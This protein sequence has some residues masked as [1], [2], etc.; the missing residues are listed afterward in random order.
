[1]D[2]IN[3]INL[4]IDKH[5]ISRSCAP[6]EIISNYLCDIFAALFRLHTLDCIKYKID[7]K[8]KNELNKTIWSSVTNLTVN[9]PQTIHESLLTIGCYKFECVL[10]DIKVQCI[11]C[12][13]VIM[14]YV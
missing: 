14:G 13:E 9:C 4:I 7:N 8:V 6:I 12:A 5:F 1:M 10:G 2:I 3:I 11:D